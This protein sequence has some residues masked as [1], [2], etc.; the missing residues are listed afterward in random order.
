M[1]PGGVGGSIHRAATRISTA[2]HQ[3]STTPMTN[4]RKK[5]R[6]EP[7]GGLLWVCVSGLRSKSKPIAK[8]I[9]GPGSRHVAARN[10]F[11][12]EIQ[13]ILCSLD[14]DRF[15]RRPLCRVL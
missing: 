3:S 11:G 13:S 15:K 7:F 2:S 4:H 12:R 8:S 14:E 5:D 1:S 9:R 6:R 10:L